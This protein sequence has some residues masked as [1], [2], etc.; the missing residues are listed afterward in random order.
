[1]AVNFYIWQVLQA[2]PKDQ[3]QPK[4]AQKTSVNSDSTAMHQVKQKIKKIFY[5]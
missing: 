1:M 2:K 5:R 3:M 4:T